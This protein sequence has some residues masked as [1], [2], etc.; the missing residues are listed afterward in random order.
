MLWTACYQRITSQRAHDILMLNKSLPAV[1]PLCLRETDRDQWRIC[2]FFIKK[3]V[4]FC[5]IYDVLILVSRARFNRKASMFVFGQLICL[6]M[7]D[8]SHFD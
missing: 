1:G 5:L 4:I 8:R 7:I 3:K 6:S 2:L